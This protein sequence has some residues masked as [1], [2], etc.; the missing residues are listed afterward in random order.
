[1][2]KYFMIALLVT[3]TIWGA[4]AQLLPSLQFGVKAGLNFSSLKSEE[5]GWLD[6]STRTGYQAGV[7]ARIGGAGVHFQ[8]ELYVTGKS[9]EAK[10]VEENEEGKVSF[11]SLDLPLLLGTRIG[12]GPAGL[13]I[14]AGPVVSFVVD[15]NIGQSLQQ[16][17]EFGE[18][19]NQAW[20]VTGGLGLDISNFRVD[21]RYEH[22]LSEL[23]KNESAPQKLNLWTVGVGYRLF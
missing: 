16:V 10:L 4:N 3:S 11:T 17:T 9:S 1:M 15:K 19:K 13:R 14:V 21:L 18:Y 20:A 12:L 7:W 8:P 23:S 2:K 5:G 6:A 22:G